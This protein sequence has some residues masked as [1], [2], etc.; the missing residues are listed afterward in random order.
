MVRGGKSPGGRYKQSKVLRRARNEGGTVWVI[1]LRKSR[2]KEAMG[3]KEER[4][5]P[6]RA[7][8]RGEEKRGDQH[9]PNKRRRFA[10]LER[11]S[12]SVVLKGNTA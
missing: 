3:K 1:A 2:R 4:A 9:K 12:L 10:R 11:S 8:K 5:Y 6:E 7:E